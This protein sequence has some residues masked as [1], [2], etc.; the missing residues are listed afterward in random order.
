MGATPRKRSA[1][2]TAYR[3]R[4]PEMRIALGRFQRDGRDLLLLVNVGRDPFQGE[5]LG[6]EGAWLTLDPVTGSVR[7]C[8]A[9]AAGSRCNWRRGRRWHTCKCRNAAPLHFF[10]AFLHWR[11]IQ[12]GGL[13]PLEHHIFLQ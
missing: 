5:L 13:A 1:L 2:R 12:D 7:P 3:L 9:H 10:S 11:G 8:Q 4:R 6:A